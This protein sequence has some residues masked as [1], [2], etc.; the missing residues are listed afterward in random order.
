MCHSTQS[1]KASLIRYLSR[2]QKEVRQQAVRV[3]ECGQKHLRQSPM[4]ATPLFM[5]VEASFLE[6]GFLTPQEQN[7]VDVKDTTS[8]ISLQKN[9]VTSG[10]DTLTSVFTL[11]ES[12][13]SC[14]ER[15][16]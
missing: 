13:L 11:G 8:E 6:C 4:T 12:K 5:P 7:M 10:W 9:P 15:A 2:D 14:C 1:V 16:Q 3:S